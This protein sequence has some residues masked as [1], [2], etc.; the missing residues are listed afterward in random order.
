MTDVGMKRPHNEDAYFHDDA[1]QLY[2]VADGMGGHAAGEVASWEA[3]QAVHGMVRQGIERIEEHRASPSEESVASLRRLIESGIQ[4]ATYMVFGIAEQDPQHKGMG[5]TITAMLVA[6]EVVIVGSVG[7]SRAYLVREGKAWQVT[8]DHT[9]VQ[10][11]LKAGLVT[12][13]QAKV[14][15]KGNVI[16]RAVGPRDY[17]Q[18]DT[19]VVPAQSGDRYLLCSDGL[20]GYLETPEIAPIMLAPTLEEVCQRLIRLANGRGGKDNI[21]CVV[22]ELG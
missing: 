8:E 11:Q 9:L 4:A 20:H 3:V 14:S 19:F 10:L 5:T 12:P 13:D 18:V 16:T 7:D 1:L 2:V 17:V 6:G 21:T 15:P 22:I